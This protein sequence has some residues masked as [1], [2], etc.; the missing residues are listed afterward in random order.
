M[1][2]I[3][4]CLFGDK[5]KGPSLTLLPPLHNAGKIYPSTV[6]LGEMLFLPSPHF[7]TDRSRSHTDSS[8]LRLLLES[9]SENNFCFLALLLKAAPRAQAG[10]KEQ[11]LL[12]T[13]FRSYHTK[14]EHKENTEASPETLSDGKAECMPLNAISQFMA[15]TEEELLSS[16]TNLFPL[17]A[18]N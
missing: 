4:H 6:I 15:R 17:C 12:T 2:S 9:A 7:S 11:G 14:L 18:L 1:K 10:G 16:I 13:A 5:G 3:Y 8:F